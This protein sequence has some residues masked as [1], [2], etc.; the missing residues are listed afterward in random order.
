MTSYAVDA[1]TLIALMEPKAPTL[2][3]A[4]DYAVACSLLTCS[5]QEAAGQFRCGDCISVG[6][7]AFV[8]DSVEAA[9][10]QRHYWWRKTD[11]NDFVVQV[12]MAN[13]G[14]HCIELPNDPHLYEVAGGRLACFEP[15]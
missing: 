7:F 4:I 8:L 12:C 2:E 13:D 15:D 6:P 11:D 3:A 10:D 1:N 14:Y 9:F 5:R